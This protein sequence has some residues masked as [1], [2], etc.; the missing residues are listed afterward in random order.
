MG[1]VFLCRDT[2][3]DVEVAVKVL[4]AEV[5]HDEEAL[6]QIGREAKAA[7]RFRDCAGILSLHGFEQHGE[8]WYLVMEFA[9][10]GSIHDRI[11]AE[12][13]LPEKEVRRLGAE[14]AE[15]LA[16]AHERSIL[17]RDVKPANILLDGKGR[18]K[19]ADFG[20]AKVMSEASS[21]MSLVTV[22]GTPVYMAPEIILQ[23]RVD[24]R[25]DL[26]SLGCMLY[27]M[28]TGKR[29]YTGSYTEIAMAKTTGV[30]SLPDPRALK[31][32]LSEEFGAIVLR[33]LSID[34]GDRFPDGHACAAALREGAGAATT[35]GTTATLHP[36]SPP[37]PPARRSRVPLFAGIAVVAALAAAGIFAFPRP[38][39]EV[40]VQ[41]PVEPKP[42]P[43]PAPK[44]E[45]IPEPVPEPKPEPIPEPIPE[46]KPEPVP[47]PV[48]EPKPEPIPEPVPVPVPVPEPVP[49]PKPE[50][51][52]EPKPEPPPPPPPPPPIVPAVAGL[53][54]PPE[55]VVKGQKAVA[56]L[57]EGLERR[58]DGRI[59]SRKDGAELVLVPGGE[60]AR[61]SNERA[62]ER[63]VRTI[64]VSAFLLDRHEV[65]NG[66]FARF[67]RETG[68]RTDAEKDGKGETLVGDTLREVKGAD[69][70]H[71]TGPASSIEGMDGHPVVLVSWNDA[72]AYADWA[73][74]RLPTEA[75]FERALR[76]G[77]DSMAWPWGAGPTPGGKFAN[78]SDGTGKARHR[79]WTIVPG[80]TDEFELSSPAGAFAPNAYGLFDVA[81]NVWE[82]CADWYDPHAYAGS[83]DRDP[84]GAASG[85]LRVVRGGGWFGAPAYLRAAYRERKD[86]ADRDIVR[87]FR[88]ARTP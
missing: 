5:T 21:R 40:V 15:A 37:P 14:V 41:V 46:P 1:R 58:D 50:P 65:T 31:P 56:A 88:L 74:R 68:H 12:G 49:E 61:G 84:Q 83:P 48:P 24:G 19:V 35:G 78:Y 8:T 22:A 63:P 7:A 73:G 79:T 60:F 75:E 16:F 26:Y 13:A 28:S 43:I 25:A 38:K 10:G 36:P 57:P 11:K 66:Q 69:W 72:K 34:P 82:W 62:E 70:L 54:P 87:G 4:P 32:E 39:P 44:P 55:G 77:L 18:A 30:S 2:L 23:Q 59:F 52:P 64:H 29:P 53:A 3:L 45:P 6:A 42:E 9:G 17:H 81:G 47:E 67:V 20:I 71:P 86:P 33:L 51:V 80:Y 85:T 76:G 27:E